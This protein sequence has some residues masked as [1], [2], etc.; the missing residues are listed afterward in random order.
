MDKDGA[1]SDIQQTGCQWIDT[2]WILHLYFW[3]H[4]F[5]QQSIYKHCNHY[6]SNSYMLQGICCVSFHLQVHWCGRELMYGSMTTEKCLLFADIHCRHVGSFHYGLSKVLEHKCQYDSN[7]VTLQK[8]RLHWVAGNDFVCKCKFWLSSILVANYI[9][10]VTAQWQNCF[11]IFTI[12][13]WGMCYPKCQIL[14]FVWRNKSRGVLTLLNMIVPVH[15]LCFFWLLS[16]FA[17][18]CYLF[19]LSMVYIVPGRTLE[20]KQVISIRIM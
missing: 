2:G 3:V 16:V 14:T 11:T 8:Y 12:W 10:E 13:I 17:H 6:S 15:E 1:T 20:E 9:V 4:L 7:S 19:A 5:S 18:L